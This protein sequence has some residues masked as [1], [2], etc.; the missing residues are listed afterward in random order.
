MR[1]LTS[2]T[3][4]YFIAIALIMFSL[5]FSNHVLAQTANT[6]LQEQAN[7]QTPQKPNT[8]KNEILRLEDTIRGNKEQPQV[9]TIVP[10]QLPVHQRINENSQWQLQVMQLPPIERTAFLRKL[11]VV[12]ELGETK[13]EN[14]GAK[15]KAQSNK[16][17]Q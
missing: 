10:W 9:L 15:A 13:D 16:V 17:K 3:H 4:A 14:A 2:N 1:Q 11:A 5:C 6:S 8:N 7:S 12:A